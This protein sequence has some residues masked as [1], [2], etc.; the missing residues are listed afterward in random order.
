MLNLKAAA[1]RTAAFLDRWHWLL[2]A[3]VAP[4]L[5]LPSPGRSA[6]LLIVPAVWI[7]AWVAG[8]EQVALL[9]GRGLDKVS[10]F[11]DLREVAVWILRRESGPG[12]PLAARAR[13]QTL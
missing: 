4:L 5:L 13:A 12:R 1:R 6:A 3:L 7:A 2:L 10:V 11:E 8:C 9:A